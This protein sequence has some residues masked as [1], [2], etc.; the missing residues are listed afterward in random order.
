MLRSIDFKTMPYL[1]TDKAGTCLT[2]D[3]DERELDDIGCDSDTLR[4]HAVR[5]IRMHLRP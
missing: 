1:F 4:A 3:F 2:V 5:R